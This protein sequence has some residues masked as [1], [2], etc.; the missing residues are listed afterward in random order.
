MASL[1]T[2]LQLLSDLKLGANHVSI[3]YSFLGWFLEVRI[4][5]LP[6]LFSVN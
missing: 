1:I 3:F 6:P 2:S 4:E 5:G